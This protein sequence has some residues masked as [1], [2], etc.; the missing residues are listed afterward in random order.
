MIH[1]TNTPFQNPLRKLYAVTGFGALVGERDTTRNP[2][3]KWVES[4][5]TKSGVSSG[6]IRG[7]GVEPPNS[8]ET[9]P[10]N[11][12]DLIH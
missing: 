12:N 8:Y 11:Y 10:S 3:K 4:D 7:K 5:A 1:I 6:L 9:R 2:E